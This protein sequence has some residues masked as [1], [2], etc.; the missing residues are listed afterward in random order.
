MRTKNENTHYGGFEDYN[1][2]ETESNGQKL[3]P[4][5]NIS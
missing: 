5:E 1:T 3:F 2:L 4:V